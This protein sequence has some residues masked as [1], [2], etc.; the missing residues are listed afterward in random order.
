MLQ[1]YCMNQI[2]SLGAE[3]KL[4]AIL[5]SDFSAQ[6]PKLGADWWNIGPESRCGHQYRRRCIQARPPMATERL[7][8]PLSTRKT[9][10]KIKSGSF[11]LRRR[12]DLVPDF[13][14]AEHP[15]TTPRAVTQI[16]LAK[17]RTQK[18]RRK[19]KRE[20]RSEIETLF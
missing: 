13:G 14:H 16:L 18:R 15:T 1:K 4:S 6:N 2:L 17:L 12:C 19:P 9:R 20:Q 7:Y 3:K 11:S 8:T 5:R 10:S